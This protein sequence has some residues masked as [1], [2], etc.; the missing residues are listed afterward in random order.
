MRREA[1]AVASW[2]ERMQG[3]EPRSGA[4]LQ[5]DEL[6]ET[7]LPI[8]RR[9]VDEQF[10][11]LLDTVDKTG[12]WLDGLKTT[13]L[14]A[15]SAGKIFQAGMAVGKFQGVIRANTPTGTRR[16]LQ[17]LSVSS[18]GTVSP[19]LRRPSPAL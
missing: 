5:N 14:P 11:V 13:V 2:V 9:M 16:L 6:P 4:F 18:L 7:L 1:P 3:P 10:P 15:A 19:A 12:V 8:L 17:S